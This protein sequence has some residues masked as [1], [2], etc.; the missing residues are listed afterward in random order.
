MSVRTV[1]RQLHSNMYRG[2]VPVTEA[3]GYI[4]LSEDQDTLRPA[5]K[6][7]SSHMFPV[8]P[9]QCF[10][11]LLQGKLQLSVLPFFPLFHI[12]GS[13]ALPEVRLQH[14]DLQSWKTDSNLLPVRTCR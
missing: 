10:F 8:Y 9:V 4:L 14:R 13:Q 11:L 3:C 1:L 7:A 2:G 12:R 5:Q 6:S